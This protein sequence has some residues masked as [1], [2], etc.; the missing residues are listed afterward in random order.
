MPALTAKARVMAA[1]KA[2]GGR[3]QAKTDIIQARMQAAKAKQI[4]K[5]PKPR[6][7]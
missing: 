7:A 3:N 4:M 2:A 6:S 5:K 1:A